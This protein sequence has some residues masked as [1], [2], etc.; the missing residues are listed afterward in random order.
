VITTKKEPGAQQEGFI[1][2]VAKHHFLPTNI[3][4]GRVK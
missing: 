2:E 1:Y 3:N 4:N